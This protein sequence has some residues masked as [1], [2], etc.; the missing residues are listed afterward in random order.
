MVR[1]SIARVLTA[2]VVTLTQQHCYTYLARVLTVRTSKRRVDVALNTLAVTGNSTPAAVLTVRTAKRRADV[3]EKYEKAKYKPYDNRHNKHETKTKR[4]RPNKCKRRLLVLS[5][6]WTKAMRLR[7]NKYER[8]RTSL[9]AIR[10]RKHGFWAHNE[11]PME[12]LI[13]KTVKRDIAPLDMVQIRPRNVAAFPPRKLGQH[14]KKSGTRVTH[15]P[16]HAK[17]AMERREN[18]WVIE[19]K[20]LKALKESK[21]AKLAGNDD[22]E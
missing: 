17:K 9:K 13:V 12:R 10:A 22:S 2:A 20:R 4:L 18:K 14:G 15:I 1:K 7:L 16:P 11:R 5:T 19:K 3:Y 21:L 6:H 8:E